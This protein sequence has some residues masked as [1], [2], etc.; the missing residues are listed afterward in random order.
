MPALER[1]CVAHFL[2]QATFG[3][4]HH[5]VEGDGAT[6]AFVVAKRHNLHCISGNQRL[7]L[8]GKKKK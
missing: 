7:E 3:E 5:G 4:A 2:L 6:E 1:L 8:Q